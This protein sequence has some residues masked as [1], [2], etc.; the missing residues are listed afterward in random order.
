MGFGFPNEATG[1]SFSEFTAVYG[2][3]AYICIGAFGFCA[4]HIPDPLY[5]AVFYPIYRGI[6]ANTGGSCVGMSATSAQFANGTLK[7]ADF[8]S[9][10]LFPAGIAA[11]GDD[12]YSHNSTLDLLTGPAK[13]QTLWAYV[14][15]NHGRQVS[16]S[17][18]RMSAEQLI[19]SAQ[20]GFMTKQLQTLRASPTALVLSMKN[21]EA[22]FG[23]HAILPYAVDDVNPSIPQVKVYDNNQARSTSPFVDFNLT[24]DTFKF[25][26]YAKSGGTLFLYPVSTWKG[27]ATFPADIPG[28]IG[29]VIFGDSGDATAAALGAAAQ[30]GPTPQNTTQALISTPQGQYGYLPNGSFVNTLAGVVPIPLLGKN[31]ENVIFSPV[32]IPAN[33][34]EP[35]IAINSNQ[36]RYFLLSSG[37]G[38]VLGL[39]GSNVTP[40][41]RDTV[42]LDYQGTALS[43]YDLTPQRATTELLPQIGMSLGEQERLL[44]R[45]WQLDLEGGS[46]ARFDVLPGRHGLTYAN[47]STKASEHFIIVDAIDG[48]ARQAATRIFGPIKVAAGAGQRITIADWP[49]S[50]SLKVETDADG[51][52]VYEKT[53]IFDGRFC[54]SAD[55][56]DNGVPDAC[57]SPPHL[58]LP[59]IGKP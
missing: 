28:M 59:V 55:A 27:A 18:W 37:S 11:R 26:G 46:T 32:L 56:D 1:S 23:G 49:L 15:T 6:I 16:S 22:V 33:G 43:G 7:V 35:T 30:A 24:D 44:F 31:G 39:R 8:D 48:A 54:G 57:Q 13:P 12:D 47:G 40:G 34:A 29:N 53:E 17:V 9:S 20:D 5:M 25:S 52:G 51:D 19:D 4:T 50:H 42:A 21:P 58:Y 38:T 45:F 2:N 41:D 36:K 10:A 14:R 3:N